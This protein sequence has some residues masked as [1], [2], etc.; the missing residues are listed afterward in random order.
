MRVSLG[1]FFFLLDSFFA[2]SSSKMESWAQNIW[3]AWWLLLWLADFF[4]K[5]KKRKVSPHYPVNPNLTW[6][7]HPIFHGDVPQIC[8]GS[9]IHTLH[10]CIRVLARPSSRQRWKSVLGKLTHAGLSPKLTSVPGRRQ[11]GNAAAPSAWRAH[12]WGSRGE[13]DKGLAED[14][15]ARVGF[16]VA[17][18]HQAF[19]WWKTQ[20]GRLPILYSPIAL[21]VPVLNKSEGSVTI[22]AEHGLQLTSLS[23]PWR[24]GPVP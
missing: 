18:C 5:K 15:P 23:G 1:F 8:P 20:K 16:F 13:Q 12:A 24:R 6:F 4:G 10:V 3:T 21:Q 14:F 2:L 17:Y 7:S 11:R 9:W 19:L 22:L